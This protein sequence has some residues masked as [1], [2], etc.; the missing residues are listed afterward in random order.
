MFF[1]KLYCCFYCQNHWLK[2]TAQTMHSIFFCC[3]VFNLAIDCA[4][5]TFAQQIFDFSNFLHWYSRA[6]LTLSR[7]GLVFWGLEER[8]GGGGGGR[9]LPAVNISKTIWGM[10]MKFSQVDGIGWLSWQ[11][12]VTLLLR[13]RSEKF[14]FEAV[15]KTF[16]LRIIFCC[17]V[18]VHK[19]LYQCDKNHDHNLI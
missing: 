7:L 6:P 19:L 13:H 17:F 10:P 14:T 4:M 9:N 11:Q 15:Q 8:G 2:T 18:N 3:S 1:L 5:L 12:L 16:C